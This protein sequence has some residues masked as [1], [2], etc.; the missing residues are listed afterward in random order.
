[1]QAALGLTR[2]AESTSD[3]NEAAPFQAAAQSSLEGIVYNSATVPIHTLATTTMASTLEPSTEAN[4]HILPEPDTNADDYD[5]KEYVKCQ[6]DTMRGQEVLG[7]LV[8]QE[9][10]ES[11]A[12]G[13]MIH[14]YFCFGAEK[15]IRFQASAMHA[16]QS[17]ALNTTFL[18][19]LLTAGCF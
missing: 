4:Q 7:H 10:R 15:T 12:S 2:S 14:Q 3:E 16:S 6:L 1:M 11:R 19:L 17:V 9:G 13:G 8:F 18:G 5:K